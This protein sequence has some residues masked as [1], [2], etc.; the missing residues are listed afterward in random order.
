M[1]QKVLKIYR[2]VFL[3]PKIPCESLL[4]VVFSNLLCVA[5]SKTVIVHKLVNGNQKILK[6]S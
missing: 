2:W 1:L 4:C 3:V 6:S 5:F